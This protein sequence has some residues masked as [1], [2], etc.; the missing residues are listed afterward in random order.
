MVFL[1]I[2]IIVLYGICFFVTRRLTW[3]EILTI[4]WFGLYFE[5]I[6]DTYLDLKYDLY[7][8]FNKGPDWASLIPLFGVFPPL[9]YLIMNFFPAKN[10]VARITIYLLAWD[11]FSIGYELLTIKYGVFY[12][13]GWKWWYSAIV[14]PP[15]F[16]T[17]WYH[18][19]FTRLLIKKRK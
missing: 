11:A 19:K 4:T 9:N 12:Y 10:E 18:L 8:Y 13:N 6:T 14:Y 3:I 2:S 17:L 15:I 5:T 7:G 16:L 1:I